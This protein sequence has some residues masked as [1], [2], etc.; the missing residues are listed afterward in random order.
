MNFPFFKKRSASWANLDAFEGRSTSAGINITESVALGIPA[1]YACIRV[2]SEAIASLPLLTYERFDNGDKDRARSFSLFRLLHDSPNPLM[3]SFELRELLVGHLCLRGNAY[4]FI[5][6]DQGEVVALWPLHPDKVTVELQGRELVYKH[7]ADGQ[8]KTYPMSDI[9][10]I[11]GLSAD[12]IIG[13]SPLTLL[14]DCF[15]Y[16]KAVQEYSSSYFKNDASPGGILTTPNALSGQ[17]QANLREAWTG[18]HAGKGKHHKVAVLDNG[19]QWQSVGVSPQDSQLIESQKF[20]VVEIARVF[21]VPLNLVMDYERST[22]ANV[23]EQLRSFLTHTL[24]PWLT[25][26]EQ[27]MMKSL[28]TESEKEKFFIE[29]LTNGFLRADTK[30]RYESYKIAV[31]SGFLTIDEVRQLENMN[32]LQN[33]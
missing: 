31:E 18:G 29:H 12:G 6:R 7:Q 21:R 25:R 2:L 10:H 22:Y 24:Q 3:T 17:S 1:V 33:S 9:L 5:E 30:T 28:L 15:G 26:I 32:S 16:S 20:S 8:E 27:A 19:L 23:T 13:Y 4:C 14:R 11:R